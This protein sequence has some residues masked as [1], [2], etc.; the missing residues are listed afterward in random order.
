MAESAW[1]NR[2]LGVTIFA[3]AAAVSASAATPADFYLTMLRRGVAA[4]DGG[5]Y[6][7]A[8]RPLRIAAFG[9]VDSIEHY[10]TAQIYLALAFDRLQNEAGAREAASRVVVAQ[11]VE[12]KYKALPVPAGV[13]SAFDALASRLLTAAEVGSLSRS[14]PPPTTSPPPASQPKPSAPAPATEKQPPPQAPTPKTTPPATKT[15]TAPPPKAT[16]PPAKAAPAPK[17]DVS[18][19]LAAADRA[20][21]AAQLA[22]ARRI[23]HE[24]LLTGTLQHAQ[25]LRAAEGLYRARDFAGALRAFAAVGQLRAGEEPYNY[26]IAVARYETRDYS[27]AKR[28]LDVA[29]PYIELTPDVARYREKITAAAAR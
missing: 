6:E 28:A 29:L 13:R 25:A 26:Y 14:A 1:V 19:R 23:Y 18:A 21:A 9:A 27:G 10:Q 5:R 4:F 20:L 17:V 16:A 22:E 11:K 24:L 7:E 3:I 15:A 2:V 12:P 8:T